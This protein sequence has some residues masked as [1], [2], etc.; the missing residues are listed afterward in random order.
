M[1]GFFGKILNIDLTARQAWAEAVPEYVYQTYLG[2]KGLA[3]WLMDVKMQ[4]PADPLSPENCLIIALGPAADGRIWGSSR[5]GIFSR[6]PQTGL[7]GESYAGGRVAGHMSRT[8]Y[9]AFYITGQ[10]D[11]PV[12]LDIS[13]RGVGFLDAGHLWGMDTYTA[14]DALTALAGGAACG[15]VVIG[16]AGENLVR[17][18]VVENDY[19]RSAGRTGMG[20]V[21]GS[22]KLKGLIFRGS[23]R[24]PAAEPEVLDRLFSQIAENRKDQQAGDSLKNRGTARLVE[25]INQ[26]GA[27]PSRYWSSGRVENI[28]KINAETLHNRLKVTPRACTN[29][30]L[31][32]GRLSEV[33]EGPHKGLKI[34]GPEYETIFA[35]GGLALIESIEEIAYLND[36]C[37]RLGMDT[38]SAGNLAGLAIEA[39]RRGKIKDKIDY[40]DADA[41]ATL[42][43]QIACRQ[44]PGAILARGTALAAAEWGLEDLA[45]QVKGLE[46][47]GYDPRYF[48]TMALAYATTPRGACHLRASAFRAE[49][50]GGHPQGTGQGQSQNCRRL[51]R[52]AHPARRPHHLPFLPGHVRQRGSFPPHSRSDRLDN[53]QKRPGQTGRQHPQP[54]PKGQHKT[55]LDQATRQTAQ[56]FLQGINRGRHRSQARGT[57]IH[58]R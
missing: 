20:A 51:R 6:S 58:D 48:K 3:L 46:P 28:V 12:A 22:K 14:Q 16:P 38:I 24:R 19:W 23:T 21:L 55:G 57:G 8:G 26:A 15:V 29:C 41:V 33:L 27:F 4:R 18:S 39:S 56:T 53:G 45:V 11:S 42:L 37:D 2:G 54:Q 49:M 5:Y 10:S 44:G 50:T 31:A 40:G 17:F 7:Y 13:D 9:D 52:P 32:C 36:I 25:A 43:R 1:N 30:F 35:F 47:A 34:E